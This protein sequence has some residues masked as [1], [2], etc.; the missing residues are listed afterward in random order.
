MIRIRFS[1]NERAE[2]EIEA[3]KSEW[4]ELNQRFHEFCGGLESV[5][6]ILADVSFDPSPY[7]AILSRLFVQKTAERIL[8][9]VKDG[10]LFLSGAERYLE[11]FAENIPYNAEQNST[12]AYHV[13][14]D[15]AGREDYVSEESLEPV[16][17]FQPRLV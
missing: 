6:E 15:R 1:C 16:I 3:T 17:D 13:H 12:I 2:L 8:V 14:F 5:V 11:M 10:I 7:H 4:I 9:R